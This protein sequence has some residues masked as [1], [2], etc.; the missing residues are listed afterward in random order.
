MDNRFHMLCEAAMRNLRWFPHR[1]ES[2]FA[3]HGWG[4]KGLR[5]PVVH[6]EDDGALRGVENCVGLLF[7]LLGQ[8][9]AESRQ[10][11]CGGDP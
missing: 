7:D 5:A 1:L 4:G 3:G 9:A 11:R 6:V 2:R 8:L 10:L